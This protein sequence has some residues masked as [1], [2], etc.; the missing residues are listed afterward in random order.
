[1]KSY[2]NDCVAILIV[3]PYIRKDTTLSIS[4]QRFSPLYRL[5]SLCVSLLKY[6]KLMAIP[7]SLLILVALLAPSSISSSPVQDPELVVQ[8]VQK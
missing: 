3:V 5:S 7:L 6:T 2:K 4:S 8:E 1:M